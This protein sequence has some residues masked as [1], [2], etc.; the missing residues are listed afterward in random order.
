MLQRHFF[1]FADMYLGLPETV[2]PLKLSEEQENGEEIIIQAALSFD[3]G[4]DKTKEFHRNLGPTLEWN[5]DL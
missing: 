4:L 5:H 3:F 2:E 1:Q